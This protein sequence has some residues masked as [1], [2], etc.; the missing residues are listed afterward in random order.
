MIE[1]YSFIAD[2]ATKGGALVIVSSILIYTIKYMMSSFKESLNN[3]RN[4]F[5]D[6]LEKLENRY[7]NRVKKIDTICLDVQRTIGK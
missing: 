2:I 4:D 5:L 3:Q 1:G 6:A 7:D